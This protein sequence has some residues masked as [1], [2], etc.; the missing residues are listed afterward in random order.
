M[1]LIV[2]RGMQ[3]ARSHDVLLDD[4]AAVCMWQTNRACNLLSKAKL[5]P[6]PLNKRARATRAKHGVH[7]SNVRAYISQ[8]RG[9]ANKPQTG[10]NRFTSSVR[11]L[12]ALFGAN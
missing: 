5:P 3:R 11:V 7:I 4:G 6:G 1:N 10:A 12:C 9:Q 2:E 8:R